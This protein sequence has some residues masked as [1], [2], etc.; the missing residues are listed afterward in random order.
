MMIL[1]AQPNLGT[2]EVVQSI[3]QKVYDSGDIY[4]GEYEGHYC[5]GCER[6]LTDRELVDGRCPDHG[7]LLKNG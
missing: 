7:W 6:F 2:K 1:S 4:Y 3:L 5:V